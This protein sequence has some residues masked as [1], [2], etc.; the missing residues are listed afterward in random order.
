MAHTTD[1]IVVGL[2]AM[3]S[4]ALFHLAQRGV[5][6]IGFDRFA[7]PHPLGSTHGL[8]RIIREAYYEHPCYVPF[9]Q[10]AYELWSDLERRAARRL[11][12]QTGGLMIGD[13]N[14]VLVAGALRSARE[15]GLAHELLSAS[16]V[17]GRFPGFVL[18]NEMSGFYEPRAGVLDPEGCVEAHL[19]LA[20]AA[21]A[22]V[23]ANEP[24]LEWSATGDRVRVATASGEYDAGRLA[25]CAGA[26][27]PRLIDDE[28]VTLRVERQVMNWFTPKE[29]PE[30]FSLPRCPIA[31]VEYDADRI[32][33]FVPDSG[34]GVKAAIHHEG[35]IT[36]P[37]AVR[38]EVTKADIAPAAGMLRTF[39]PRAA[40][41][42][43]GSATCLYTNTSDGHFFIAPHARHD[44]VLI[45]S[46]C[47]GHGFKFAS[48]VGE[49][50][51]DLTMGS[52][53]PDLAPFGRQR[54]TLEQAAR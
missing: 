17:H 1:V 11:F 31:M 3:G 45:V 36:D 42:H 40:G 12:H 49:A 8:S 18:P 14:G 33:Y 15:H 52:P 9:V 38:R 50:V 41:E 16:E 54:P 26:W 20:G 7:P 35:E 19:H 24:V 29:T 39:L 4:A 27:N 51:A 13:E 22:E 21:G 48:A 10:R 30:L 47:S 32:F 34:D 37:D 25:L 44:H 5:R 46:A 23:H 53:R 2:G 28:T 43:R 6:V